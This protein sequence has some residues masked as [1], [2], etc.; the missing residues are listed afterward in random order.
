M[1]KDDKSEIFTQTGRV[2]YSH[3]G[4]DG[5]LKPAAV[6]N[7]CQD[8]ASRHAFALGVSALHV[9]ALNKIW[10][11]NRYHFEFY[12][13]PAWDELF[14]LRSWRAPLRRLYEIRRFELSDE[15]GQPLMESTCAWV[16]VDKNTG[17]PVRL[18]RA[19]PPE[20]CE[21]DGSIPFETEEIPLPPDTAQTMDFS[22]LQDDMDYNRHANNTAYL[23]W[24]L[25]ALSP[26]ELFPCRIRKLDIHYH[27]DI[28]PPRSV[29]VYT[30]REEAGDGLCC[31]QAIRAADTGEVLTGIRMDLSL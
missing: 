29:R 17:K 26:S 16:L 30:A 13:F 24:S 7:I 18:S 28:G 14:T 25:E 19:M 10:V 9:A 11:V 3:V 12:R 4:M 22:V 23:K 1:N 5:H 21:N 20:L 6:L 27:H 2:P 15:M 31:V 8:I